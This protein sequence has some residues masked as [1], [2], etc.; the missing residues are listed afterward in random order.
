MFYQ[1]GS[2]GRGSKYENHAA[3]TVGLSPHN[4]VF[5]LLTCASSR[6]AIS[7]RNP[8]GCLV[9]PW[10]YTDRAV[11][12]SL[13]PPQYR[14]RLPFFAQ[15]NASHV[16]LPA[17]SQALMNLEIRQA[18]YAGLD[19]WA[20]VAYEETDPMSRALQY[21]LSSDTR[22]SLRFCMFTALESWGDAQH[23]SPLIDHHIDFMKDKSYLRTPDG[24]PIYFLGF[25]STQKAMEKWGGLSDSNI[26]SKRSVSEQTLRG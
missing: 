6:A 22:R 8:M 25:V 26:K 2:C 5:F 18:E 14:W 7:R 1:A 23:P 16:L 15:Q 12:H 13:S 9:R 19:Y 21:Y 17:A 11:T 24:R 4:S 10:F 20:F 3:N